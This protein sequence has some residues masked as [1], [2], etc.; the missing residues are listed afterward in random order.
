MDL[1]AHLALGIG[2]SA[3]CGFR[4]FLPF[5]VMSIAALGGA[6]PLDGDFAW[7]SSPGAV[8]LLGAAT[9]AEVL[10][11]YVPWIDNLLDT[12]ATPAAVVAGVLASASVLGDV[13]APVQ[14][15]L[16]VIAGGGAA[17]LVQATTVA[18]RG[19]SSLG[20]GGLGNFAVAT[21]EN[22]AATLVAIL[23]L[24]VPVLTV[25]GLVMAGAWAWRRIRGRRASGV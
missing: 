12:V 19:M 17:G 18:A 5:F 22:G 23:A 21:V 16:A 6:L 3:A 10:A 15:T 11:Y 1:A 25:V 2:L 4:V 9:A 8:V 24:A 14:W 7:L 20:T 13:P